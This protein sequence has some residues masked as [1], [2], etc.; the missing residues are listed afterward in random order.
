MK[1][2][3]LLLALIVCGCQPVEPQPEVQLRFKI[4]D[5]V[6]LQ[7]G[8]KGQIIDINYTRNAPYTIRIKTDQGCDYLYFREFELVIE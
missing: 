5:I 6:D 2:L 3:I 8:G 1:K 7:I 4:G